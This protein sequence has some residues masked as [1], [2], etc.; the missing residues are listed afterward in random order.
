[1]GDNT[2]VLS[3]S[4]TPLLCLLDAFG[5][6]NP[7]FWSRYGVFRAQAQLLDIA[8]H[9]FGFLSIIIV[10]STVHSDFK[11]YLNCSFCFRCYTRQPSVSC[12]RIVCNGLL[13]LGFRRPALE[14]TSAWFR[15]CA[16]TMK[17]IHL[18]IF[19][20]DHP[21]RPIYVQN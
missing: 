10:Y 9:I 1:M 8:S 16:G 4:L 12:F 3:L 11:L 17:L 6:A 2:L 5:V 18:S 21:V 15:A 19:R 14:R 20:N 13:G 7:S